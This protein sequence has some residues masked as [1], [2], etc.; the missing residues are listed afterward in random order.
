LLGIVNQI[1]DFSKIE[2]GKLVL[3]K[4][5]FNL[6]N[7]FKQ[8]CSSLAI[9]VNDKKVEFISFLTPDVPVEL[10]GDPGRLRQIL[11]NLTS[12]AIKFTHAGKIFVK[13]ETVKDNKS[14]VELRFLIKDTGIGIA[15]NKQQEIFK[16]FSQ[17]DG[18]TTREYGGTGLG[19]TISKQLAELMGGQIGLKSE[20][21][22]GSTFWFTVKFNKQKIKNKKEIKK[23][24]SKLITRHTT[25]EEKINNVRLLLVE[26]YPTNQKVAMKHLSQQGYNITLA[27][28][29]KIAVDLF[30]KKQFDLILMDIQMPVMDGY[31]CATR[32]KQITHNIPIVAQTAYALPQDSY[33]CFD[34]GCDDYISKPISLDQFL[35][36]LN[37]YLS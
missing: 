5:P 2:A 36:K 12:N 21:G 25:A 23:E 13:C 15:T 19:T 1:L 22:K 32:I 10:M 29:G 34:A 18:S 33:K 35:I 24:S 20:A 14:S 37:K 3:E 16:G 11:V 17:A 27:E 30:K 6:R 26:D 28:N 9:N 31:E 8:V 7:T 4:I